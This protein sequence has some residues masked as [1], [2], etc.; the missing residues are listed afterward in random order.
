M[1]TVPIRSFFKS[2]KSFDRA[3]FPCKNCKQYFPINSYT[4]IENDEN[5]ENTLRKEFLKCP[6]ELN[7][8]TQFEFETLQWFWDNIQYDEQIQEQE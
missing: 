3:S 5:E 6:D 1:R 8:G 2:Y 4:V 7:C